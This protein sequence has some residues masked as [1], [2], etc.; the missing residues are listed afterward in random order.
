VVR[1]LQAE[2]ET[3][4]NQL[5][6][7]LKELHSLDGKLKP[8]REA[9]A[10][11]IRGMLANRLATPQKVN[12]VSCWEGL[13]GIE[14]TVAD[15]TEAIE[16]KQY[17]GQLGE[18]IPNSYLELLRRVKLQRATHPTMTWVEF[19]ALALEVGIVDSVAI[20]SGAHAGKKARLCEAVPLVE[21]EVEYEV[22]LQAQEEVGE[23]KAKEGKEEQ[24]GDK[25]AAVEAAAGDDAEQEQPVDVEPTAAP[26]IVKVKGA[27]LEVDGKL[28]RATVFA[29]ALGEVLIFDT[30]P[31]LAKMPILN[32]SWL[33]ETMKC[34]VAHNHEQAMQYDSTIFDSLDPR[35]FEQAKRNLLDRGI[36]SKQLLRRLWA[37][38]GLTDE[39]YTIMRKLLTKF[40]VAIEVAGTGSLL[41]PTFLPQY[42]PTSLWPPEC[43]EGKMQLQWWYAIRSFQPAGLIERLIVLLQEAGYTQFMCA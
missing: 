34:V 12:A 33:A 4:V 1:S 27:E 14:Q 3:D 40:E 23:E 15:M 36:L 38:I 42:L 19:A 32:P 16:Q 17:F 21:A 18:L 8:G 35:S 30:D 5:K 20:Q 29:K 24:E 26:Q 22:E 43:A 11:Q 31:E 2:E 25:E 41:V 37:P 39:S 6:Y 13:E 7:C 9:E 10:A 28:M